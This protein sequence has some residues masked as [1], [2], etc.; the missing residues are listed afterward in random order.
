M[1]TPVHFAVPLTPEEDERIKE[2]MRLLEQY[3]QQI[4]QA[5]A[6]IEEKAT[7]NDDGL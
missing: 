4:C 1:E 3:K 2:Y 7:Q 5:F 6:Y